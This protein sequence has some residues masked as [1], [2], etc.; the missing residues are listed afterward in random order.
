M[1]TFGIIN[2]AGHNPSG[3]YLYV[4]VLRQAGWDNGK[5]IVVQVQLTQVWDVGQ[6]AIFNRAD[7]VV[8]QA[9]SAKEHRIIKHEPIYM[10]DH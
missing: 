10:N 6:R 9:K 8:A 4:L 2:P 3:S 1:V 5:G 7:L